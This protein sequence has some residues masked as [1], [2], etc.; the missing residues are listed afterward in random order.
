MTSE[1]ARIAA[2]TLFKT[3][4]PTLPDGFLGDRLDFARNETRLKWAPAGPEAGTLFYRYEGT[5]RI[6]DAR[7]VE[8]LLETLVTLDAEMV[9][10]AGK[11]R[12]QIADLR[13]TLERKGKELDG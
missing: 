13:A 8:A 9:S 1:Q 5:D 12:Q 7:R 3:K 4:T 6:G 2:L 11:N 10:A